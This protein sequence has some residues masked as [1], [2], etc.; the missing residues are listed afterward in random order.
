MTDILDH[1]VK[2]MEA[3]IRGTFDGSA[4]FVIGDEGA[5]VLDSKGVRR[6][7]EACKVTLTASVA[8]FRALLDGKL[9]P[10]TAFMTGKL[11]VD[12]DMGMALKLGSVL[13]GKP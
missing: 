10:T 9:K 4:K 12:G 3:K 7:D 1:A 13:G 11:K 6:S 5:I 2:A 8:T